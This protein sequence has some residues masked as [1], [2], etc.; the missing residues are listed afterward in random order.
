MAQ[1]NM[2]R[3]VKEIVYIHIYIYFSPKSLWLAGCFRQKYS[4]DGIVFLC[5]FISCIRFKQKTSKRM[6]KAKQSSILSV[7]YGHF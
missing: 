1:S 6:G 7:K 5:W 2:I 4:G 3:I